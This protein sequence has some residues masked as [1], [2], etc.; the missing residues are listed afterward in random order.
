MNAFATRWSC[1][2]RGELS[3]TKRAQERGHLNRVIVNRLL[4]IPCPVKFLVEVVG[5]LR[6]AK[7]RHASQ[8]ERVV[9]I[10][11]ATES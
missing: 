4:P 9:T 5:H 8:S 10:R 3:A 1:R 2:P 6:V 11:Q 7:E